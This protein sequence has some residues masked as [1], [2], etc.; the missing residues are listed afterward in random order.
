MQYESDPHRHPGASWWRHWLIPS[1]ESLQLKFGSSWPWIS[2]SIL[3]RLHMGWDAG[4]K[5]PVAARGRKQQQQQQQQQEQQ[6]QQQSLMKSKYLL[7]CTDEW[8]L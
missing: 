2:V 5:A 3:G 6:Q 4:S 1:P 8:K 7:D